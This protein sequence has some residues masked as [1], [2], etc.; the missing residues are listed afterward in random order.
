MS[1]FHCT[2]YKT[3]CKLTPIAAGSLNAFKVID[4]FT[5]FGLTRHDATKEFCCPLPSRVEQCELGISRRIAVCCTTLSKSK[6]MHNQKQRFKCIVRIC[7]SKLPIIT[8]KCIFRPCWL[9]KSHTYNHKLRKTSRALSNK[10]AT[11]K[12]SH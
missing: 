8:M 11:V 2:G 4:Q 9:R 10:N 7:D 3:G 1:D 5:P 6:Q 12:Q